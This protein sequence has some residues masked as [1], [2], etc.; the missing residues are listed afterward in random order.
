MRRYYVFRIRKEFV[1]LYKENPVHLFDNLRRIFYSDKK[2]LQYNFN[3]YNQIAEKLDKDQLDR[4]LYIKL[5]NKMFYIKKEEQHVIN[6]LYK[7]EVS[8]LEVKNS[9]IV[10]EVNNNYSMFFEFLNNYY[11]DYF[12][13]DFHNIDYFWLNTVKMLV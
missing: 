5:H 11:P 13:C 9:Y 4:Y 12:V 10:I 6:N 2:Y 8:I 1:K 7:D 3:L